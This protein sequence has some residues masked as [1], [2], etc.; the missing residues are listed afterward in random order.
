MKVKADSRGLVFRC[1]CRSS[2]NYILNLKQREPKSMFLK[3][4]SDS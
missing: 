2:F 3:A 4:F 1:V